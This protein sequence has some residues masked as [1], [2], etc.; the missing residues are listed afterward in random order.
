MDR[1]HDRRHGKNTAGL[2][3][4][5]VATLIKFGADVNQQRVSL[6]GKPPMLHH[7]LAGP[8]SG[9]RG[10]AFLNVVQQLLLA[11]VDVNVVDNEG[12]T[13]LHVA[14]SCNDYNA[15]RTFLDFAVQRL[16]WSVVTIRNE[17]A[18]Q[19][20]ANGDRALVELLV[21]HEASEHLGNS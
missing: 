20:A 9:E 1:D 21:S 11:G 14:A 4:D 13:A 2:W 17:S 7:A 18:S 16:R 12:W 8:N 3:R 15:L 5:A 19:L 6:N 10:T